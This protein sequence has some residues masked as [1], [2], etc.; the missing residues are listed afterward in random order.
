M[1][2]TSAQSRLLTSYQ[3]TLQYTYPHAL[4]GF[5][6]RLT[7]AHAAALASDA[8]VASV[9]PRQRSTPRP[10]AAEPSLVGTGSHR[11]ARAASE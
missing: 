8:A 10:R 11:P 6:A 3:G 4:N 1:A 2:A 7:A 5:A 9:G